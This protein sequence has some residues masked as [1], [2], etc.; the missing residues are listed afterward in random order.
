[1]TE[2]VETILLR[3]KEDV[4]TLLQGGNFSNI[5]GQGYDFSELRR[6]E[7][8]DDIRHI[9]WINSAKLGEPYIKKMHEERELNVAVSLLLDGRMQ[10]NEKQKLITQ[11]LALL[12]YSA[13]YSNNQFEGSYFKGN[14]FLSFE[15]TKNIESLENIVKE[16]SRVS[17]LGMELKY[18]TIQE[19]LLQSLEKKSL[20][21]IVGDFLDEIELSILAQKHEIYAILIRDKWEEYPK[22]S[23]DTQL[24]NPVSNRAINRNVSKKTLVNYVEKLKTHDKKL[25]EHFNAHHIKYTKIY[26][27]GE[28]LPKLEALFN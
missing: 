26:N 23:A 16:V 28:L 20:L 3:A 2:H 6:Y 11:T 13:L 14:T 21:F 17:P 5:L 27:Y 19:T 25:F 12:A 15:S 24:F 22:I 9:S 1:M 8:S 10:I 18:E 4:Y 7:S